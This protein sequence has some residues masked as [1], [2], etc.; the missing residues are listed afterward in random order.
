M[1][2]KDGMSTMEDDTSKERPADYEEVRVV[3]GGDIFTIT[4]EEPNGH[5]TA[6]EC[7]SFLLASGMV[8][9]THAS[10][11]EAYH[12]MNVTVWGAALHPYVWMRLVVEAM[13]KSVLPWWRTKIEQALRI[14]GEMPALEKKEE[15]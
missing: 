7:N 13:N 1:L 14:K 6:V 5:K 2:S 10:G 15:K 3:D 8:D 11:R 12:L 4:I 9:P